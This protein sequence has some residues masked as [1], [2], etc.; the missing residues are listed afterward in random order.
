MKRLILCLLL[1][2]S[3]AALAQDIRP[4][5]VENHSDTDDLDKRLLKGK[6]K[7]VKTLYFDGTWNAETKSYDNLDHLYNAPKGVYEAFD[8]IGRLTEYAYISLPAYVPISNKDKTRLVY[9]SGKLSKKIIGNVTQEF[10]EHG[11]MVSYIDYSGE[12]QDI[13]LKYASGKK[14][15]EYNSAL[16]EKIIYRYN[17]A[18][19]LASTEVYGGMATLMAVPSPQTN[20]PARQFYTY[21]VQN[22]LLTIKTDNPTGFSNSN[23]SLTNTYGAGKNPVRS[24][25]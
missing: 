23:Y 16:D 19:K 21:D 2:Q 1:C 24:V 9:K 8:S 25:I 20:K 22:R 18:G 11:D 7:S 5:L 10:N 3:F 12:K 6:V 14:T 17:T 4:F 13:K 15:E